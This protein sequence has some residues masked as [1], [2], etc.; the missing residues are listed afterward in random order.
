M[1]PDGPTIHYCYLGRV[2]LTTRPSP[3]PVHNQYGPALLSPSSVWKTLTIKDDMSLI[4][5]QSIC[6]VDTGMYVM[7]EL[8]GI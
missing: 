1:I 4:V 5:C 8:L 3:A 7:M 2:L 6:R